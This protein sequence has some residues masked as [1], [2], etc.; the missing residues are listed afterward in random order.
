MYLPFPLVLM[1]SISKWYTMLGQ[2]SLSCPHCHPRALSHQLY[3]SKTSN[4]EQMVFLTRDCL[5]W[6]LQYFVADNT[7]KSQY[8][9]RFTQHS[10]TTL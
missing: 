6:F 10:K 3:D 8:T 7:R 1:L 5:P 9:R 4:N 2:D